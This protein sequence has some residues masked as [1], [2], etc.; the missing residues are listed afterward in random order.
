MVKV[1]IH[2]NEPEKVF[3][4]LLP[5]SKM[6]ILKKEKVEDMFKERDE[7]HGVDDSPLY[8]PLPA[9]AKFQIVSNGA[10]MV[11]RERVRVDIIGHARINM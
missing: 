6:P 1:H 9:H 10:L 2:A 3:T 4:T 5:F 11:P 8:Q 7:T